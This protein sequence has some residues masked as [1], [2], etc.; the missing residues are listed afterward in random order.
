CRTSTALFY[1]VR[2]LVQYIAF[3]VPYERIVR[4]ITFNIILQCFE[5]MLLK[6][7]TRILTADCL[8]RHFKAFGVVDHFTA[9]PFAVVLFKHF[10]FP[11]DHVFMGRIENRLVVILFRI[12]THAGGE[13]VADIDAVERGVDISINHIP[14]SSFV[15]WSSCA[16]YS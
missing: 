12:E 15:I 6:E 4:H 8:D 10:E 9:E 7:W 5:T 3:R 1:Y 14:F 2:L 11:D 16:P 13:I